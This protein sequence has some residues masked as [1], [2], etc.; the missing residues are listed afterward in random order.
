MSKAKPYCISKKL[1]VEAWEAVSANKGSAGVDGQ[2][3]KAFETDLRGNLYKIWNRM[4]SGCYFPPAVK[5]VE[6]PKSDGKT[7]RLG[8]PTVADRVAQMVVKKILEP[9]VEPLFHPD[10]YGYRPGKRALDAVGKARERCMRKDYIVDVDIKGFFDN[11]D[12]DLVMQFVKRHT[13]PIPELKWIP[14]YV[15]RWLK[16]PLQDRK[17]DV[18]PRNMGTPQGGVISPLLANVFLHY[19]FD[20]WMAKE[21]RTVQFERYA[22]DVVIHCSSLAQSRYIL[23]RIKERMNAF[24]L[25]LHPEKTRI[26]YCKDGKRKGSSEHES[27]DFL[28]YTFRPRASKGKRMEDKVFAGF[29]PAISGK[30]KKRIRASIRELQLTKNFNVKSLNDIAEVLNPLLKGWENYYARYYPS[31][32][33]RAMHYVDSVLARWA[34]RKY[35]KLHRNWKAACRWL[36]GV[37][38]RQP[39]LFHHWSIETPVKRGWIGRAV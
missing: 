6:I 33:K 20:A 7:R 12:H 1:V 19:V 18:T 31:E 25:E 24:K 2:S 26:V 30:A 27:F 32:F 8:I 23:R 34:K 9:R 17:G 21:F 4:S 14:I 36:M 38:R 10:S 3:I 5:L 16:A 22:D 37:S 35:K 28:G 13:D 29:L 15:E 39:D 11:L